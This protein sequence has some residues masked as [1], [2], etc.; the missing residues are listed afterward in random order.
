MSFRGQLAREA[1]TA[2]G[3]FWPKIKRAG[4]SSVPEELVA[5][6][7]AEVEAE[8]A[9][10]EKI[11]SHFPGPAVDMHVFF[12]IEDWWMGE[13]RGSRRGVVGCTNF[14]KVRCPHPLSSYF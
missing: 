13:G 14:W 6:T 10:R 9:I 5:G 12:D 7:R 2:L 3:V 8:A 1:D 11:R 4:T